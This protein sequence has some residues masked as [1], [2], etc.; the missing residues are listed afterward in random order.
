MN[1][2]HEFAKTRGR[3]LPQMQQFATGRAGDRTGSRMMLADSG[4]ETTLVFHDRIELPHFAAFPLLETRVGR[5]RLASYYRDHAAIAR[6]NGCGFVFEAPTWRANPDWASLLGYGPEALDRLNVAAIDLLME[7][8]AKSGFGPDNAAVSGCIGPRGDGYRADDAMSADQARRYHSAQIDSFRRANA[9]FVTALTI[10]SVDEAVGIILAAGD[11]SMPVVMSFTVETDGCL[12]SG[13]SLRDAIV[14]TDRRTG[15][16]AAYYM[17]NC[18][19]PS[20]FAPVMT[21]GA[22]WQ[23]RIGGIRANASC[24]S[25]AELDEALTLDSR[26]PVDL[27]Q[28]YRDLSMLLPNLVVAG[29]CCGTDQRHIMAIA[30]ALMTDALP[31]SPARSDLLAD[32]TQAA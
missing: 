9:D 27:A 10:G 23:E 13:T 19:H 17:V 2:D 1:R 3:A 32:K 5:D 31:R 28:R 12:P 21:A 11:A 20:H 24:K 14:E 18:A 22:R 15:R 29:G 25:H 8:R 26:D 7:A 4:L 16:I 6:E 30:S